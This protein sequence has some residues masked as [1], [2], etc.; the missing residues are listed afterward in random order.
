MTTSPPKLPRIDRHDRRSRRTR[1]CLKEALFS[2]VLEKGYDSVTIEDITSRAD[3]GRTTFYLHY[4]DKDELLLE[5]ID[6]IASDLIERLPQPEWFTPESVRPR[7]ATLQDSVQVV[8]EHAAENA[9]L[10][11]VILRGQGAVQASGRVHA[12]I[13]NKSTEM[14]RQLLDLG[15]I[16]LAVPVE[17]FTNYLA[18]SLLAL[19]TWWLEADMPYTPQQM[20][21]MYQM[22]FFHGSKT[23]LGIE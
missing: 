8:F 2:L 4:H 3:L 7:G 17:I 9:Q 11:R 19:L 21:E 16:Q 14:I 15:G 23:A 12:I 6:S 20:A 10:Y 22:M 13:N 18:G 1:R 5:S